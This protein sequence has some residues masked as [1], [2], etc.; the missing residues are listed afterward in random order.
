MGEEES[1]CMNVLWP[2]RS[3]TACVNS[4]TPAA[5]LPSAQPPWALLPLS[6]MMGWEGL[7]WA[8]W[9]AKKCILE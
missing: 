2:D 4:Q 7:G 8:A 1:C 9:N 3:V 6:T 5:K